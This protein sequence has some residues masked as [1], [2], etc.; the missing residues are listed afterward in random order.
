MA[1]QRERERRG[2]TTVRDDSACKQTMTEEHL[3]RPNGG[4]RGQSSLH[5]TKHISLIHRK[6]NNPSPYLQLMLRPERDLAL[7]HNHNGHS[8]GKHDRQNDVD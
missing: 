5:P 1:E 6:R 8:D 7:R 2:E 4:P 3:T